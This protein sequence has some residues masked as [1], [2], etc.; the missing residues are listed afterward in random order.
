[1]WSNLFGPELI[2][3]YT[4][5]AIKPARLPPVIHLLLGGGGWLG[6]VGVEDSVKFLLICVWFIEIY[7][8]MLL[9]QLIFF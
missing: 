6:E 4:A 3:V 7:S 1:M 5:T 9:A 8:Y 2:T